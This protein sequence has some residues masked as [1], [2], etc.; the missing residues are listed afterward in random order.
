MDYGSNDDSERLQKLL[1]QLLRALRVLDRERVVCCGV[2]VPQCYT[3][4]LLLSQGQT[5]MSD[6]SVLMGIAPSTL[7]R[8]IASLARKGWVRSYRD[9]EDRR[10]VWV[11]VTEEGAAVA[12]SLWARGVQRQRAIV[13]RLSQVDVAVAL[14]GLEILVGALLAEGTDGANPAAL[15]TPAAST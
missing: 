13:S 4:C 14:S 5:S 3:L 15:T 11:E 8:N 9:R 12:R 1:S 10:V 2:T 7:T 6:L